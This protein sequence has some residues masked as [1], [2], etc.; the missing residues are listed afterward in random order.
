MVTRLY[1]LKLPP[2]N[3]LHPSMVCFGSKAPDVEILGML[4]LVQVMGHDMGGASG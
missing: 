2:R 4:M 3:P 1:P